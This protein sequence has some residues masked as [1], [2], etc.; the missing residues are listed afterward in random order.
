MNAAGVLGFGPDARGPVDLA[1]L[2]AF[3]TNPISLEPHTPAAGTRCLTFPGGFLLHTGYPNPGIHT[4]LRDWRVRWGRASLP[5]LVHLLAKGVDDTAYMVQR[6]EAVEGVAGVELGIPPDASFELA[7]AMVQAAQGELPLVVRLPLERA[8][9]LAHAVLEAG[10]AVV[11]LGPP[12]GALPDRSGSLVHGRL[13]GPGV[14]PIA[15]AAVRNLVQMGLTVIGAGGIYSL[16][17]A[18]SMLA[19]GA[20]AVQLDAVLWR[21]SWLT[22]TFRRS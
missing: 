20:H 10:L 19:A 18:D 3:V 21:E 9:E 1:R 5:V 16:Q 12:R 8:M 6:L 7:R 17:D 13:Y 14:L 15:L 11:S 22:D 2:G 4:A